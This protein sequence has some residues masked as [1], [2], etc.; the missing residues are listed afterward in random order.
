MRIDLKN[1]T[2]TGYWPYTTI[3]NNSVET[4]VTLRGVTKPMTAETPSDVYTVLRTNGVIPDM[5]YGNN[6]M[7][8]EWV[9]ER[10]WLFENNFYIGEKKDGKHWRLIIEGLDYEGDIHIN[11]KFVC[12]HKGPFIPAVI[13]LDEFL[14]YNQKNRLSVTVY[15]TPEEYAQVGYTSKTSTQRSRFDYNWDFSTRLVGIGIYGPVYIEEIGSA[16]ITDAFVKPR[17]VEDDNWEI[18]TDLQINCREILHN[19]SVKTELSFNGE[20]VAFKEQEISL[21][22][23]EN[24]LSLPLKVSAPKLWWPN[25]HGEQPLYTYTVTV[26]ENG[27]EIEQKQ[28]TVAFRRLEYRRANKAKADSLPYVPVINGRPIYIKGV[29][30]VP[31]DLAKKFPSKE[32][33]NCAFKL[34]ADANINL[35]RVWGG[36]ILESEY[37]YELC[38]RYG[39]MVWQEFIQSSSGIDNVPCKDK[40]YLALLGETAESML[41]SR[42]NHISLTF[43]S[44]GNELFAEESLYDEECKDLPVTYEDTNIAMLK[45]LVQKWDKDTFMLPSS[46]SGPHQFLN[47]DHLGENYDVHGPWMYEGVEDQYTLYNMSD[48]ILHGEFGCNGMSNIDVLQSFLPQETLE[49]K[50]PHTDILWDMHGGDWWDTQER[51]SEIFGKFE[52]NELETLIKCSQF[53]QAEGI[54]YALQANMRRAMQNCG[55]IIW[56]FNEPWPNVACTSLTS[57]GLKP[58]LA[59]YYTRDSYRMQYASLK[60]SKLCW[61]TDEVFKAEAFGF[62]ELDEK[63]GTVKCTIADTS[64]TL[65]YEKEWHLT[66][67]FAVKAGEIEWKIPN[68]LRGGFLV[69]TEWITSDSNEKCTSNEYLFLI[70]D[71]KTG[72]C[73]KQTAVQYYDRC[74]SE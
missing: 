44:G 24:A 66:V 64:G 74:I 14:K 58:K 2:V 51:D 60:Y 67:Q 6:S 30:L 23:G 41:K 19:T 22:K 32:T 11:G 69:K 42:R 53:I 12:H 33:Y 46:A 4:G 36:G 5:Y 31:F 68:N 35:V 65:L 73:E 40:D 3:L 8:C 72:L 29:N 71:S 56:Q 50:P 1:W 13:E 61:F 48:S 63:S 34:L 62:N 59:Y 28:Y 55:S 70:K 10:W 18:P 21:V 26:T 15:N 38:D 43:W 20:I 49:V 39:I 16:E 25:K 17:F 57:Y 45:K 47:I 9:S 27:N 52:P 54:R 37:F 7:A